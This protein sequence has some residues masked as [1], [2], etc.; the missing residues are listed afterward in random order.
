MSHQNLASQRGA[1]ALNQDL[2]EGAAPHVPEGAR[3]DV[4]NYECP[5]GVSILSPE[6]ESV[7]REVHLMAQIGDLLFKG[8]A[9]PI[10]P[11]EDERPEEGGAA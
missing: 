3:M 4:G 11:G 8:A 10:G 5:D 7:H 9:R 6:M 2:G 1:S